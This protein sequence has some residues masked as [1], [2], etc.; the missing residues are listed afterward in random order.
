MG[1][2]CKIAHLL[3]FLLAKALVAPNAGKCA[4]KMDLNP[5]IH[6]KTEKYR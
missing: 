6:Y 5:T 1:V 4:V 3:P 2:F